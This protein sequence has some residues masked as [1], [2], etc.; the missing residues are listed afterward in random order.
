[1]LQTIGDSGYLR[2]AREV[3]EAVDRIVTGVGAIAGVEL[4]VPPDSTLVVLTADASC[5]VFT[6]TDEMAERGWYVQPQMRFNGR[7]AT[8]HLSVSAA[9]L[10]RVDE[11]LDA[12]AASVA[13]ARAAGPVRVDAGVVE[14][15]EALDPNA[16]G[17]EEF[18]ALLAAAGL[19]QAGTAG[20]DASSTGGLNLP[21]RMAEVNALLDVAAPALRE[22]LLVAFLDRLARPVRGTV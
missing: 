1:M 7:P 13:A 2:L 12:L 20:S 8:L 5:D 14:F 21:G 4:L 18:D 6:I 15:L 17:D 22:A 19:V 16:L 11:L 9:T 3:F 10:A